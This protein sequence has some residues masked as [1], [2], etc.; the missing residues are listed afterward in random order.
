MRRLLALLFLP[1][2]AGCSYDSPVAYEPRSE[3]W[4]SESRTP[5]KY[6]E[7]LEYMS[8]EERVDFYTLTSDEMRDQFIEEHG[9]NVRKMLDDLL[10]LG[11]APSQVEQLLGEPRFKEVLLHDLRDETWVYYR[12]NGYRRSRY[13]VYFRNGRTTG[14]DAF[15]D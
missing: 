14:W 9:I 3:S 13:M 8:S 10:E 4:H 7:H 2:L 1:A 11:M 15:A 6:G 5:R 12:F